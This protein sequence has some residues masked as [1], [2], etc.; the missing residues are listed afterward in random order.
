MSEREGEGERGERSADAA[1]CLHPCVNHASETLS[2]SLPLSPRSPSSSSSAP[3][4][5]DPCVVSA[6]TDGRP[7]E[8]ASR[9]SSS[10][11][12]PDRTLEG[13]TAGHQPAASLGADRGDRHPRGGHRVLPPIPKIAM[14]R[15]VRVPQPVP[16]VL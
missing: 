8:A 15:S 6:T 3:R 5:I 16:G 9:S 4:D 14:T 10:S 11:S 7:A 12:H 2:L 1:G 13:R